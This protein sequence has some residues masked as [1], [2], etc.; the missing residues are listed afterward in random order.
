MAAYQAGELAAF[1]SLYDSLAPKLRAYLL[2][3]TWSR[4]RAEDLLQESFLQLHR[5]R[6]TYRRGRPVLPWAFA[7]ARHVFLMDRRAA[8]RKAR[9]ETLAPAELPEVPVPAAVEKLAA[10]S[11]VREA[12][13]RL[14]GDRREAVV[15]HHVFG[16]S[17]A[18]I[19]S[20]LGI[21]AGTAKLRAHRAIHALRK[22]LGG[23]DTDRADRARGG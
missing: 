9:Y 14:D 19:G 8:R 23:N 6:H 21:R 10:A 4:Q 13:S 1:E 5:S 3:L 16:L 18:E 12:L 11:L 20:L 22:A 2:S 7:I 17:F 15:L